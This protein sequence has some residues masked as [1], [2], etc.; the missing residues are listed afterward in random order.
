VKVSGSGETQALEDE[1]E[2]QLQDLQ[3]REGATI[4][5]VQ[6]PI[7]PDQDAVGA[8]AYETKGIHPRNPTPNTQNRDMGGPTKPGMGGQKPANNNQ[9][10][11][12][13]KYAGGIKGSGRGSPSVPP[14]GGKK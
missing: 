7:A 2:A 10:A 1:R 9:A 12:G 11:S 6:Y 5:G 14:P 8:L 3:Y 4:E 13:M